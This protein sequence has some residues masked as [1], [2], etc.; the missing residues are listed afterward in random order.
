MNDKLISR[1]YILLFNR[2]KRS[3][4]IIV[5]LL[6]IWMLGFVMYVNAIPEAEDIISNTDNDAFIVL[7]GGADRIEIALHMFLQSKAKKLLISGVDASKEDLQRMLLKYGA[8]QNDMDRII[9]GTT[10]DSTFTNAIEAKAF[11]QLHNFTSYTLVT[12]AYHMPRASFIF[13]EIIDFAS[14]TRVAIYSKNFSN[15]IYIDSFAKFSML[16]WEYH[17]FIWAVVLILNEK[18]DLVWQSSM[19][20]I[21]NIIKNKTN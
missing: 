14:Q 12:S 7:T 16:F 8:S 9:I 1:A 17:K 21:A 11:L 6:T 15:K 2:I 3:I 18:F 10:A 19:I 4:M 20:E 13:S 5:V